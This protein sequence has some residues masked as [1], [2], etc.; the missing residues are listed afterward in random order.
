MRPDELTRRSLLTRAL[1]I[2][3]RAARLSDGAVDPTVGT[4]MRN[5]GYSV[6][7]P[8]VLPDADHFLQDDRHLLAA[9][10]YFGVEAVN[11][12]PHGVDTQVFFPLNRQHARQALFPDRPE[13]QDAFIVLNANRNV[14][15]KRVD[16]TIEGFASFAQSS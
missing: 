9:A 15:R 5:A 13:L 3:L 11:V 6:D 16:L 8:E 12:I 10:H 7:F 14:L 1:A 2:A 4:A